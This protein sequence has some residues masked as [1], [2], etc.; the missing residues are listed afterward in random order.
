MADCILTVNGSVGIEAPC[1]GVPVLT[2]AKTYYHDADITI[3]SDNYEEF[4][5]KLKKIHLVKKLSEIEINRAKII[6]NPIPHKTI[7]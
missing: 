1:Y 7:R 5:Q 4:I 3:N 6:C 2:A